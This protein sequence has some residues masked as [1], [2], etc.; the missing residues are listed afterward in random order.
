MRSHHTASPSS[1]QAAAPTWVPLPVAAARL[2][3]RPDSVITLIRG[4][5]LIGRLVGTRWFIHSNSLAR[6]VARA[7]RACPGSAV[8][9]RI[10]VASRE[11]AARPR[12]AIS[13]AQGSL[14]DGA[15]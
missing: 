5:R 8:R 6:F 12:T 10:A 11:A 1:S 7:Q 14:F 3:R 9:R 2:R 15:A 13:A 4:G